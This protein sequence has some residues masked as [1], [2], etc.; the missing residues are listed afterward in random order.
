MQIRGT[1]HVYRKQALMIAIIIQQLYL[2][3]MSNDHCQTR[4]IVT[5]AVVFIFV[6]L[7]LSTLM[8]DFAVTNSSYRY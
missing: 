6:Y 8:L 2:H 3:L 4:I 5:T 1:T 7:S